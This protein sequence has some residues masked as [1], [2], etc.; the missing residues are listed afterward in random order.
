MRITRC[1]TLLLGLWTLSGCESGSVPLPTEGPSLQILPGNA[2]QHTVTGDYTVN[3]AANP[4]VLIPSHFEIGA[5]VFANGSAAGTFSWFVETSA[6]TV[7]FEGDVICMPVDVELGRAWIGA[8]VTRNGSTLGG[9]QQDRHQ[10]GRDVWFR[11]GDVSPGGSGEADRS[12]ATAGFEGSGGIETS[13]EYCEL[14]IW[15]NDGRP[16][17]SGNLT[18]R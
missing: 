8:V 10:P 5:R 14:K 17:L 1:L 9:F 11:V 3:A 2:V 6:G 16:I 18:V 4:T 15:P 13:A 12:T 7:D